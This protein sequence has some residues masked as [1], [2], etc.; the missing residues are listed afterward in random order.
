MTNQKRSDR[1]IK[2]SKNGGKI[3]PKTMSK[4]FSKNAKKDLTKGKDGDIIT[5]LSARSGKQL[6]L[7]N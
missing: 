4:I 7:E 1:I 2:L 3:S 5:K 6:D